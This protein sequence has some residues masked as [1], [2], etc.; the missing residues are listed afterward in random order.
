MISI[1]TVC[2][3]G[4]VSSLILKMNAE[5]ILKKYGYDASIKNLDFKDVDEFVADILI[6]TKDVYNQIEKKSVQEVIILENITE[7]KELE[8]KLIPVYRNLLRN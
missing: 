5:S 7:K 4:I 2:A 6:T 1:I 3:S 8:E